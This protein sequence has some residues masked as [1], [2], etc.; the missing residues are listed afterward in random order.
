MNSLRIPKAELAFIGGSSTLSTAFP[1]NSR[2]GKVQDVQQDLVF[3]TPFGIS[4]PMTRVTLSTGR[5]VLSCRM[6]GWRS[7][8]TR[9]AASQQ[10]FWIFREAAVTRILA[11]GGVGSLSEEHSPGDLFIPDDYQDW[12]CRRDTSLGD[13]YLLV[14][15]DPLCAALRHHLAAAAGGSLPGTPVI[16]GGVYAVTDGRH[17]ES[18]AEIRALRLMGA[19]FV[20]QSLAPE[21]YLAREIGACYAG[22]HQVVNRAEGVGEDWSHRELREIFHHRAP[23]MAE[24]LFDA[25]LAVPPDTDCLCRE[26][27]KETLLRPSSG[28]GR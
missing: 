8:V 25:L 10:V 20:G 16:D 18:R 26:L 12:S 19:D 5:T 24:I 9:R 27:R 14:M 21:V 13:D 15:R 4:P 7:R 28:P 17:F 1:P 11:E 3:P 2:S 6:H 22:I 23:V